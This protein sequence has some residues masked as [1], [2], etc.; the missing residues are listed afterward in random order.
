MYKPCFVSTTT[1]VKEAKK[2]KNNLRGIEAYIVGRFLDGLHLKKEDRL[3]PVH[4]LQNAIRLVEKVEMQFQKRK[5]RNQATPCS[6]ILGQQLKQRYEVNK[7]KTL[8][9]NF[10]KPT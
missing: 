6:F 7:G 1:V 2:P 4:T 10:G 9:E 5:A 8:M 3:Q